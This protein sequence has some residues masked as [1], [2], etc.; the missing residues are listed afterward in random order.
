MAVNDPGWEKWNKAEPQRLARYISPDYIAEQF[1]SVAGRPRT[2]RQL[3]G[4]TNLDLVA[5]VYA[6]LRAFGLRYD[7]TRIDFADYRS[8]EQVVRS[9]QQV[10]ED[11]GSCLDLSLVFAGLCEYAGLRPILIVLRTHTLVAVALQSDFA[12]AK[13]RNGIVDNEWQI[14]RQGLMAPEPGAGAHLLARVDQA[15]TGSG[16]YVIVECTGLSANGRPD[17]PAETLPFEKA[18]ALGYEQLDGGDL[19]YLVDPSFFHLQPAKGFTPYRIRTIV[20]EPPVRAEPVLGPAGVTRLTEML[21]FVGLPRPDDWTAAALRALAPQVV[22]LP[23][24]DQPLVFEAV[25][26]L[27]GALVTAEFIRAW[28]PQV[29]TTAA[30]RRALRL[31]GS[32]PAPA[33]RLETLGDYLEHIALNHEG[34]QAGMHRW[35][36]SFVARLAMDAGLD[37]D[38][39]PVRRWARELDIEV[40]LNDVAGRIRAEGKNSRGRLIVSLHA[41]VA[42]D[43]PE[44]VVA[45][46]LL[47][48]EASEKQIEK[49]PASRSGLEAAIG[50]H[51]EWADG[52]AET[53]QLK[54][55]RIE[56]AV[57]T[58][59]LL[60]WRPEETDA[61][62]EPLVRQCQVV[63]RWSGRMG[64]NVR[65]VR[66]KLDDIVTCGAEPV[67]WL[68]RQATAEVGKAVELVRR[69]VPAK[70]V[71]LKYHPQR[72]EATL[73][74]LLEQTP[75][76]LWPDPDVDTDEVLLA[77]LYGCWPEVPG[78]LNDAY[79]H[80]Q[81][82]ARAR[83]LAGLRAVWD[84]E[85]WLRFCRQFAGGRSG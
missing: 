30:M 47:D 69:A 38:A 37:L 61:D 32:P 5:D 44:Q 46:W 43:W 24:P 19:R 13:L 83:P 3:D 33:G 78:T 2:V 79:L 15:D 68:D 12:E 67:Q 58:G 14:L 39:D 72:H 18:V 70:A 63:T 22:G 53:Y 6:H 40:V 27:T 76:L 80:R 74:R 54:L 29:Q 26:D 51:L 8:G 17:G 31:P 64:R 49:C 75:V 42:G 50:R 59:L 56:V 84:D 28:M 65:A 52:E 23:T 60:R 77:E 45:W 85:D 9:A 4:Q 82:P 10:R 66:K 62:G 73:Q 16:D 25:R 36:A 35:L 57:P 55:E 1:H 21:E 81:D 11:G 7:T 34:G 48:D 20:A 71:G 41:S